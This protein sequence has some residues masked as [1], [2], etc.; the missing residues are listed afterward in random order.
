MQILDFRCCG[1]V[2]H[3]DCQPHSHTVPPKK[4]EDLQMR[5]TLT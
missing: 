2:V 3:Q 4:E 5:R 1:I